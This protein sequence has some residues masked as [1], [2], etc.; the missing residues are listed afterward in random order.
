M[1]KSH[2][3]LLVGSNLLPLPQSWLV[4]DDQPQD[5]KSPPFI[6]RPSV[7]VQMP[8]KAHRGKKTLLKDTLEF[9]RAF[10]C[11]CIFCTH[12]ST[13]VQICKRV[14]PKIPPSPI[15]LRGPEIAKPIYSL[16]LGCCLWGRDRVAGPAA[17]AKDP[18]LSLP[19]NAH[20]QSPEEDTGCPR[21]RLAKAL[22]REG[23]GLITRGLLPSPMFWKEAGAGEAFLEIGL[24]PGGQEQ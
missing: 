14:E 2:Q 15:R 16:C 18:F 11:S 5:A 20:S 4:R 13:Y 9:P 12:Q 10:T 17:A 24:F 22:S 19:Q 21:R 1:F 23:P 8:R 3:D 6:T 7:D